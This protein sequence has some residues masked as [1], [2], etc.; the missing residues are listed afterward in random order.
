MC[1]YIIW[2]FSTSILYFYLGFL[3]SLRF[4]AIDKKCKEENIYNQHNWVK[5]PTGRAHHQGL[6]WLKP[7]QFQRNVYWYCE[8]DKR[9][10]AAQFQLLAVCSSMTRGRRENELFLTR[11]QVANM[12]VLIN[13]GSDWKTLI[14]LSKPGQR[15]LKKKTK[16]IKLVGCR[17]FPLKEHSNFLGCNAVRSLLVCFLAEVADK[18]ELYKLLLDF[19]GRTFHLSWKQC[20]RVVLQCF[21]WD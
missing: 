14:T 13:D 6:R 5:N 19:F 9:P 21:P 7:F 2:A 10:P 8:F 18:K 17:C 1:Q 12:E 3:T 15:L 20:K 11:L 4:R 16:Y